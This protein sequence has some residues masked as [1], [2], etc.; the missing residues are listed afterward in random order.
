MTEELIVGQEYYY[1]SFK[2]GFGVYLGKDDRGNVCFKPVVNS[3][4]GTEYVEEF[5]CDIVGF[6]GDGGFFYIKTN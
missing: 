6:V 1:D 5:G 3:I 2:D 4:Y